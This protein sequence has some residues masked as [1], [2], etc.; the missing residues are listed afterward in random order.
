[1]DISAI[2]IQLISARH[3]VNHLRSLGKKS[4]FL[5]LQAPKKAKGNYRKVIPSS[6]SLMKTSVLYYGLI[7]MSDKRES[8]C[9]VCKR[10]SQTSQKCPVGTFLS[11]IWSAET[12]VIQ[13]K[14]VGDVLC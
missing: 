7:V 9:H 2:E 4:K 13:L 8:Q 10:E 11:H 6:S 1:M 5:L 3:H 12:S 14:N